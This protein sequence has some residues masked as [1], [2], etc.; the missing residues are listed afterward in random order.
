M[1]KQ[2]KKPSVG[3]VALM[4]R[5]CCVKTTEPVRSQREYEKSEKVIQPDD[6]GLVS[7]VLR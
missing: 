2:E 7:G 1:E 4:K 5:R 6:E 3:I